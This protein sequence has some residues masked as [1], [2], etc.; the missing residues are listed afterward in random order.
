MKRQYVAELRDGDRVNDYFLVV[1]KDLRARQ[2]GGRFLGLVLRDKTGEIGA[3]AWDGV[4][5]LSRLFEVGDVVAA[6]GMV[7]TFQGRPQ[8]R[9]ESIAA[10]N[11]GDYDLADLKGT[12]QDPTEDRERYLARLREVEHPDLKR[13]LRVFLDDTQ[14][15][16]RFCLAS[17][18]KKWHHEYAGGLLRHCLEMTCLAETLCELFPEL[19]R[20][21][22]VTA[23][24]FHDIGKLEE[25]TH[26]LVV[27]YTDAG[28]LLGHLHLGATL[29]ERAIARLDTFPEELRLRL[30][31]CVLSHHGELQNGSPVT[32]RTAEAVALHFI[33]NLD[34]QTEAFLRVIRETRSRGQDWS[35]YLPLVDRVIWAR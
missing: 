15:M 24:F 32:P 11:P 14:L 29:L 6:R 23:I 4:D 12:S 21:L 31:H 26:D 1:R 35:D 34:A 3:V 28:K 25:M 30:I 20:D 19:N 27:D 8:V 16:D 13:L 22:L 5:A 33:D 7:H 9:I 17:A 10:L 18:G 2:N